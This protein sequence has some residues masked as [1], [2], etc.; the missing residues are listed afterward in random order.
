MTMRQVGVVV[1][2]L[3]L[4]VGACSDDDDSSESVDLPDGAAAV[5][6]DYY[7]TVAVEHDGDA[8]L[9]LVTDGFEFVAADGVLGR[10]AWAANV[11]RLFENFAVERL[12]EPTVVGGGDEYLVSQAEHVTG[13]GM[14]SAAFSVLRVVE[15]DGNWLIDSQQFIETDAP[16]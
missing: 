6:E 1:L 3:A 16:S 2:A 9:A 11:N 4:A 10:E 14:D 13:T 12:G 15:V 8:M 7:Q 5:V